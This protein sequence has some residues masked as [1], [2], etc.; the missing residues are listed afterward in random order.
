MAAEPLPK[1]ELQ[2]L[3]KEPVISRD[4]VEFLP[5]ENEWRLTYS[6]SNIVYI[7][8]AE[9]VFPIDVRPYFRL[10]LARLAV[11]YAP[12]SIKNITDFCYQIPEVETGTPN[13]WLDEN[14][15]LSAK[16]MLGKKREY[17]LATI[18]GFLRFWFESGLYGVDPAFISML[19]SLSFQGNEK[20]THVK[21]EDPINGPLT[22]LEH[23]AVLDAANN[24][25]TENRISTQQMVL[26]K[27]FSERGLRRS[28][29]AQLLV[30]DFYKK[31]GKFFVNQPRAKQRATGWRGAF[32]TFEI[33]ETLY[34]LIQVIK[35]EYLSEIKK[36]YS[37][38]VASKTIDMPL[39][40]D[41]ENL[42]NRINQGDEIDASC[43]WVREDL[44][45]NMAKLPKQ[46]RIIAFSERTGE[47]IHLTPQ[48]FRYSLGSDLDREG[49]G[50]GIIA[51]AL[52]HQDQQNAG[53]YI[54]MSEAMAHRLDAKIGPLLAPL[55]QAFSGVIVKSEK[56][57]VRGDT[58]TSRIRTIDGSE[59]VGTC[60]NFAYCGAN[61][62]ISCYTC[63][64]F[65]P[66]LDG[67]H[68]EVLADL[69]KE[70]EEVLRITNDRTIASVNDRAILAVEE[71]VKRC[72]KL[73]E[74]SQNG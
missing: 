53:V 24:A 3:L 52:D 51:A 27:L 21:S 12:D 68:E 36:N 32:V 22:E 37:K 31:D 15:F 74:E 1:H 66:W 50:I 69:Y 17:Q 65:H 49:C 55:A 46:N 64:K 42:V 18:R 13:N 57:A 7:A 26:I 41:F 59:N 30:S 72:R 60:G 71:V 5:C 56:D 2:L 62:P 48:R 63:V 10:A 70:R 28:Q 20:G 73:T 25:Y 38:E 43:C 19:R 61:A 9:E 39:F 54:G 29:A 8:R 35:Q 40:P 58:P 44:Y 14:C 67:P 33:S 34:T 45:Y 23:K 4:N 6:S 16:A 47:Q 11:F